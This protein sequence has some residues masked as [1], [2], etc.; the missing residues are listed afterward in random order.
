MSGV[1]KETR[2]K[3]MKTMEA[4]SK[5]L[6]MEHAPVRAKTNVRSSD[7]RKLTEVPPQLTSHS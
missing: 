7:M 1:P 4:R 5:Q 2:R 3:H 6:A